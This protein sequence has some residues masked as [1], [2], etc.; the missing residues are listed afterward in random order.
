MNQPDLALTSPSSTHLHQEELIGE[1]LA[2]YRLGWLSRHASLLGRKEVLTGKAKFGIFGDG[3]ELP[4][5]AMAKAFK[6]GDIR[7]GYYRDQ[8][9]MLATGM[10]TLDAFFAQLYAHPSLEHEPASGG[11]SMNGHFATRWLDSSGEFVDLTQGPQSTADISPTGGQMGRGLGIAFASKWYRQHTEQASQSPF[12]VNGN[13]ISFVTIGNAS[14]SEGHFWETINAAGVLQVPMMVSIWDDAYGISV[15][16]TY[17]TTKENIGSLLQGFRTG[18]DGKGFRFYT[19]PG[20]DYPRLCALYLKAAD[21]CREDHMPVLFHVTELTQPQGHSTSGSHERYKSPERLQWEKENDGLVRMRSW[22]LEQEWADEALLDQI[23][24][25]AAAEAKEAQTRAYQAFRQSITPWYDEVNQGL[26]ALALALSQV[27]SLALSSLQPLINNLQTEREPLRRDL[28][29]ALR[30]SLWVAHQNNLHHHDNPGIRDASKN[31]LNLRSRMEGMHHVFYNRGLHSLSSSSINHLNPVPARFSESSPELN[32]FEVLNQCF[33]YW[34][35]NEPTFF[36][37]GEDVGKI[38]DVNQGFAGLQEKHGESRV[39]DTGIREMSIVGQGLGAAMRGLRPLVEIQYLDYLL[40]A[41]QI[42]SD[43]AATLQY[44]SAGGQKAPL[45]VRTRGH[46]LEGIWH[47]G[48]PMGMILHSLRGMLVLVPR[49]MVQAAG[50]Y[51]T[52]MHCDEPALVVECL[53]GYRLKEKR[54]DNLHEF[55]VVPGHAEILREGSDLTLVTYG[56]CCRIA[57]EAADLLQN[58]G[59]SIEV[60]D[61]QSL[62][63]FD[64]TGLCAQSLRK[65]SRLLI[66]D[67]DVPGGASSYLLQQIL[68]VQNG[69]SLLDW[70]PVTLTA[71]AHR[72]AYGSDGD[73]FSKPSVDDVVEAVWGLMSRAEPGYY[74]PLP[75]S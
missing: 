46:R 15:P 63:P 41:L 47:S 73:Y 2:D 74:P 5:L 31:L 6:A 62:L 22:L 24:A 71:Q 30:R 23:E 19:C 58:M 27:S 60:V 3:K 4:Q 59:L 51:N 35:A 61:A 29:Q 48:S 44:R 43:D 11:R 28:M 67:E 21:A 52:L 49:N 55:R 54:P 64:V 7:T 36:A 13:E 69:F 32:G 20:W 33:D 12:S 65:T 9:F 16:A 37:L 50:F 45:I 34:L 39:T 56:S 42:L 70:A 8:T 25:E 68:E 10:T 38:G 72:P 26:Q 18:P 17:Q 40:F 53:N 1:I 75:T 57:M 66:L 14:T